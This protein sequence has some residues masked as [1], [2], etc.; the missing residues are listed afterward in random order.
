MDIKQSKFIVFVAMVA[1]P[2]VALLL[3]FVVFNFEPIIVPPVP[4]SPPS[5]G[6][7]EVDAKW[8]RVWDKVMDDATPIKRDIC[9]PGSVEPRGDTWFM[10]HRN[11]KSFSLPSEKV[12]RIFVAAAT[13][14]DPA[15]RL[16]LLEPLTKNPDALI[17]Y[18]AFLEVARSIMRKNQVDSIIEALPAIKAALAISLERE[19][20]KADAFLLMGLYFRHQSKLSKAISSFRKS[21][22]LDPCFFDARSIYVET[23]LKSMAA[24]RSVKTYPGCLT[25]ILDLIDNLY[26]I[27]SELVEDRRLYIEMA[28]RLA[29]QPQNSLPF[30]LALGFVQFKGSDFAKARKN[31]EIALDL[32]A[33]LPKRCSVKVRE[34]A[35]DLLSLADKYVK[36]L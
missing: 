27:G 32:N 22:E 5:G 18:R 4:P 20:M 26:F 29:L 2:L 13:S 3:V 19:E 8:K 14:N 7:G 25:V 9:K 28:S 17:R 36:K 31:L 10:R 30:Y 6:D 34:K 35:S 15:Q 33:H 16:S 12:Q 11:L 1:L 23:L 21:I 24:Q